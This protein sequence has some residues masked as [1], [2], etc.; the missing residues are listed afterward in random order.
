MDELTIITHETPGVAQFD[1][2]EEIKSFLQARLEDYRNAVYSEE[3]LAKAKEDEKT[4]KR[5]KKALEE[6]K[7]EIKNVYMAPYLLIEAQIKELT[8]LIDEPIARIDVFVKQA[9]EAERAE[10]IQSVKRFYD[11]VS[12]VLGELAEPLF[13]S[14]VFLEKKWSNKTTSVK[15]WQ[16]AVREKVTK[17]TL[18][19]RTIQA[20]G[21]EHTP[22]LIARYLE[23]M[24]IEDAVAYKRTLE[25]TSSASRGE[26]E[27]TVDE[28]RVVGY[29]VLKISGNQRQMAQILE[30]LSL[31]GMEYEEL[32]DGMPRDLTER[33]EPD[34]DSF[35][36][37]DIETTGT[38]GAG[39]GDAPA[40]ITEIGAVKVVNG[41]IVEKMD[42]LC[43]PGRR[44]TP[45][46]SRL[47][48]ITDDMLADKPPV[49]DVIRRFAEFAEGLPLVGHNIRS[50]DLHYITRAAKRAGVALENEFFD[51]YI[52]S[53]RFK[54][55]KG[56]DKLSL[57]YLAGEFGIE[58]NEAHRAWCD[59]EANV[60]VY[61][62]LREMG[63][64]KA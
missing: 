64:M 12:S 3:D 37:F 16:D 46:I 27:Q 30:Q 50:S 49:S 9:E 34:F 19:I 59:A 17:A 7:K 18:D 26:V 32:E 24:D 48:H 63:E 52:Y 20:A 4:L 1:N 10:K 8:A 45:Q 57:G 22:A 31:M 41:Q 6:R 13:Q 58:L 54:T 51:T 2:F 62:K 29:K 55:E 23:T 40:E 61:F 35:V 21:G 28:D 56:W 11:G 39:C 47:T 53:K 14:P 43:N 15:A 38:F 25:A 5:L 33:T 44:I 42:W 36:A 60:G